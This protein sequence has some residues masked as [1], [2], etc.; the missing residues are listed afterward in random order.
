MKTYSAADHRPAERT[1]HRGL[2]YGSQGR[3]HALNLRD[4]GFDVT[5]GAAPGGPTWDQAKADGFAGRDAGEAR[6][7]E[8]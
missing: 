8:M 4:S 5:V 7:R 6:R 2:G 1:N 3:A